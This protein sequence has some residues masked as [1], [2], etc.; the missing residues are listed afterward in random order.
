MPNECTIFSENCNAANKSKTPEPNLTRKYPVSNNIKPFLRERRRS[1]KEQVQNAER[2]HQMRRNAKLLHPMRRGCTA[3]A[4]KCC[5]KFTDKQRRNIYKNYWELDKKNRRLWVSKFVTQVPIDHRKSDDRNVDKRVATLFYHLPL[6]PDC[7]SDPIVVCQK[8]FLATIGHSRERMIT[9]LIKSPEF[10]DKFIPT[11][12]QTSPQK[13]KEKR[14]RRSQK[15]D[16]AK[17]LLSQDDETSNKLSEDT[18]TL[19]YLLGLRGPIGFN[20]S[21]P[22]NLDPDYDQCNET[23]NKDGNSDM[24]PKYDQCNETSNNDGNSDMDPKYD[25]CN[26]TSNN[27]GNPDMDPKHNQCNETSNN[28]RNSDMDPNYNQCNE[29]SDNDGN[30][31]MD[32]D[33]D[34]G[35]SPNNGR[36]SLLYSKHRFDFQAFQR[37]ISSLCA[38]VV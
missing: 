37:I 36:Y 18:D 7:S 21:R 16:V 2:L 17:Q 24:D 23:S 11:L 25:Q 13:P 26:E 4:K 31:D 38:V 27:D 3:C 22:R 35:D 14:V 19:C 28:D 33:Y 1:V 12:P 34:P 8:Y 32:P 5:T 29:T 30:S 20:P 6:S 10:Q 9:R 15:Q